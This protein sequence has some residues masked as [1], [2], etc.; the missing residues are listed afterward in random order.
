M[1]YQSIDV[2]PSFENDTVD[3]YLPYKLVFKTDNEIMLDRYKKLVKVSYG[4]VIRLGAGFY[5]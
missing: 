2:R 1:Q 3:Y 5:G 4:P